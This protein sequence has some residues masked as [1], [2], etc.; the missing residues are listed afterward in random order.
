MLACAFTSCCPHLNRGTSKQAG[1]LLV[2]LSN[3]PTATE[4]LK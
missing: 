1:V 3:N 2:S 4:N